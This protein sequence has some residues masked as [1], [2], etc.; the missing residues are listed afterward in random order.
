[1]KGPCIP[2]VAELKG[3]LAYCGRNG[4][5]MTD[6]GTFGLKVKYPYTGMIRV[7]SWSFNK[8]A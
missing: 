3:Q 5:T 4:D 6:N 7:Q 1:M 2:N 8:G